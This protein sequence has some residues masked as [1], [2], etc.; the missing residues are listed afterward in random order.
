MGTVLAD[1][2]LSERSVPVAARPYITEE[3][4]AAIMPEEKMRIE[5]DS[6]GEIAVPADKYWGAQT[7]RSHENFPIGV[8]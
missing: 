1:T 4:G 7:E 3:K 8:G 2:T 6:M 5:H